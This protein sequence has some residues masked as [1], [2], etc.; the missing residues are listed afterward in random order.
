[1]EDVREEVHR[2]GHREFVGGNDHFWDQI[3]GLQFQLLASRGLKPADTLIDVGCGSL[4][5]GVKFIRYLEPGHYFGLE[6]HIELIVYG[7]ANELGL[8]IYR[9]KQPRFVISETFE[10]EKFG[11]APTFGI[12]QSLFTHLSARDVEA[13]LSKLR[14]VV[15][16]NCKLFTTFFE[17]DG[18]ATNPAVS[19]SHKNFSYTR[20]Q[21]EEFGERAGWRPDYI[22]EWNHPRGQ[23]L[24]EFLAA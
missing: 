11:G 12:A 20:S 14:G 13:C 4:R 8:D 24:I 3:Q 6:K 17:T 19:H 7:V 1:M 18:P 23:K 15:A 9:E 22:G 2:I 10:F 16:P 21:M 5:G